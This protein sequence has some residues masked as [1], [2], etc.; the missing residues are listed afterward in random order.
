LLVSRMVNKY[1]AITLLGIYALLNLWFTIKVNLYW[2]HSAYIINR[3]LH[4][5]P[6]PGNKTIVLLNLPENMNGVPMIGAEPEG[7]YKSL[8]EIFVDNNTPNKI[9]DASSY[10]MTTMEDG[11]HVMVINDSVIHVTLNQWG[12][13]WWYDGHGG[14]SY[15]NGDYKLNMVDAGHWYELTLKHPADQYLL[16]YEAGSLWKPVDINKK[17]QDQY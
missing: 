7:E 4:D 17:D 14:R 9:Y 2:K 6:A 15:E 1:I 16:L 11:A 8:R 10:N 3:L 5:L 12:T 13:W